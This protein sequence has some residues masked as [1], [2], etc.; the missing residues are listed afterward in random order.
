[1]AK[2]ISIKVPEI[3]KRPAT[4]KR[5]ATDPAA[6]GTLKR[7]AAAAPAAHGDKQTAAAAPAAH[8]RNEQTAAAAPGPHGRNEQTAAAAPQARDVSIDSSSGSDNPMEPRCSQCY[9]FTVLPWDMNINVGVSSLT[10]IN[11]ML[12]GKS[13][14]YFNSKLV[15]SV[16]TGKHLLMCADCMEHARS[17]I[18]KRLRQV[19]PD[20]VQ[21]DV[22]G[23]SAKYTAEIQNEWMVMSL[24]A[25]QMEL[26]SKIIRMKD[27]GSVLG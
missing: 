20:D 5:P 1:M 9:K 6:H 25:T 27:P 7:P 2:Q 23:A 24:L 11:S 18:L 8:G 12:K 3:S 19:V 16:P 4:K 17:E 26:K 14:F 21:H 13:G 10:H 15:H 22:P